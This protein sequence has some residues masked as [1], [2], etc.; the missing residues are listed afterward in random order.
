MEKAHATSE[1]VRYDDDYCAWLSGQIELI[2]AGHF[3]DLD[4]PNL[5]EE[6][7]ALASSKKHEIDSR[8]TVLLQHLLKWEFQPERRSNSWRASILEQ[9]LRINDLISESP[10]L[11]RYPSAR[12]EKEYGIARLRAADETRLPLSRFALTCPYSAS[13]ALDENF[14][15]G[16]KAEFEE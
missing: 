4:V 6:L 3:A 8:L 10:S 13:H 12:M 9:R 2:R 14:W 5:I 7:Q 16:G 11:R 15:P 1:L